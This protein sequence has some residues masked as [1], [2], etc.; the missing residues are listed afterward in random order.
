MPQDAEGAAPAEPSPEVF[1]RVRS[2]VDGYRVSQALYGVVL[3]GIPDLL[4]HGP[5]ASDDLAGATGAHAGALFRVLRFLAGVGLFDEVAPR[6]FGLTAA[7]AL[8]RSDVPGSLNASVRMRMDPANWQ[9]WGDMQHSLRTGE[10]AFDHVHGQGLFDYLSAHPNAARNFDASMT[11][12]TARSGTAITAVYDFSGI[13]RVVDVGGGQG[14]LLATVL[15]AHPAM[16]GVLFDRPPVIEAARASL[17]A[18]GVLER[19]ELV[20]GDFFAAVPSGDAYL[21]RQVLHD[22]DEARA[23]AI[24]AS[25]GRAM[26][27]DGRVLVIERVVA[28]DYHQALPTL[29]MDMVMLVLLGGLQRTEDEYRALFTGAGLRL[30]RVAPLGD[31]DQFSIFEG[32]PA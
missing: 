18:A 27:A 22:W 19:C 30:A 11:D 5:R 26:A 1:H 6:T 32:V 16:R 15:H 9:A 23:T 12:N 2:L 17:A 20:G 31:E 13:A 29:S 10:P 24:L 25:C 4:A 7:G 3:L 14:R 21:L 8:L 28:P